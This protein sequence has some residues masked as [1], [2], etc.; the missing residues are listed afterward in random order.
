MPVI[1]SKCGKEALLE[2]GRLSRERKRALTYVERG[3]MQP[4]SQKKWGLYKS[5]KGLGKTEKLFSDHNTILV[6]LDFLEAW[7]NNAKQVMEKRRD[8]ARMSCKELSQFR[9]K[10]ENRNLKDIWKSKEKLQYVYDQW[11]NA[12]KEI[13][14]NLIKR[15]K[16]KKPKCTKVMRKLRRIKKEII[17]KRTD[18]RLGQGK[19]KLLK[20]RERLV[21]EHIERHGQENKAKAAIKNAERV[22]K[23]GRAEVGGFWEYRKKMTRKKKEEKCVIKN[24]DGKMIYDRE[25]IQNEFKDFYSKLLTIEKG[26][27]EVEHRVE[28]LFRQIYKI[29]KGRKIKEVER[30][31]VEECIKEL[32]KDKAGDLQ[33]WVNEMLLHAGNDLIESIVAMINAVFVQG[34]PK[35]WNEMTIKSIYKNKGSRHEMKNRRG[36]FLTNIMSK[37]CEK[38]LLKRNERIIDSNTSE[39]QCGGRKN[40]GVQDHL[41][42]VYRA[43][44]YN[45]YVGQETNLIFLDAEKCFDKLW[46]KDCLIELWMKGMPPEEIVILYEMNKCAEIMIETPIGKTDRFTVGEIVRQGTVWGPKLCCV[47]TDEINSKVQSLKTKVG[48]ISIGARVFVDDITGMGSM[49]NMARIVESCRY[50]EENK[51]F[52]FSSEKSQIM[53]VRP[54]RSKRGKADI[55]EKVL[56]IKKGEV[57]KTEIYKY[58]GDYITEEGNK[59]TC[60]EKRTEKTN[61]MMR[62]VMSWGAER[63]TGKMA[64]QVRFLLLETI[65]I[66]SLLY[67][68]ETWGALSVNEITLLERKQKQMLATILGQRGSTSYWG[69]IIESGTWPIEQR[70]DYKR[71]MYMHNLVHSDERRE[72]RKILMEMIPKQIQGSWTEEI[73]LC[74]EKYN[75]EVDIRTIENKKKSAWKREIKMS[76]NKFLELKARDMCRESTKLRF[77]TRNNFERKKYL[78]SLSPSE[79]EWLIKVKLNM[80]PLKANYKNKFQ[81]DVDCPLCGEEEDTTEHI[82]VCKTVRNVQESREIAAIAADL[83]ESINEE[84]RARKIIQFSKMV[85]EMRQRR[86]VAFEV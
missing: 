28:I 39:S 41:F 25:E 16:K 72:A 63:V 1:P 57:K 56:K 52:T 76:I 71:L 22:K 35:Q 60:I 55:E 31:E 12:V 43:I 5:A 34:V 20:V 80:L 23:N 21:E 86:N 84:N 54:S 68:T 9:E 75:I 40:R 46:L 70:I 24:T 85:M 59:L 11:N 2:P 7:R 6:K 3:G 8:N 47:T 27:P 62:N 32:K 48:E 13:K 74:G 19:I 65:V 17:R 29:G 58:L 64:M 33:G 79:I 36:I 18:K 26:N 15:K 14:I 77:C 30:K 53:K 82:F 61:F 83:K 69:M 81:G 78:D 66:P 73:R 42:T 51:K 45:Q 67:N 44:E 4:P 38:I 49:E 50:F 10:T 37:V